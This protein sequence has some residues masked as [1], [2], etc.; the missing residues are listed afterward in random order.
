MPNNVDVIIITCFV[1]YEPRVQC[2]RHFFLQKGKNVIVITT[3]FMHREKKIRVNKADTDNFLY[4]HTKKYCKNL[5]IKR[6]LSH[7]L[8]ARDAFRQAENYTPKLIYVLVPGNALLKFGA[9][10]KQRKNCKMIVDIV[11][12]WPESLPFLSNVD[13]WPLSV[14]KKIRD[15]NLIYSDLIITECDFYQTKLLLPNNVPAHTLYWSQN[16]NPYQYVKKDIRDYINFLYLGSI[17][18]IIDIK[19]IVRLLCT[20]QKCHP[21]SIYIVGGGESK[22]EFINSLKKNNIDFHYCGFIYEH[23]RLQ[24][25]SRSCHWGINM[26]KEKTLIGLTMKSVTYMELGLPIINNVLGDTWNLITKYSSGINLRNNYTME[27]MTYNMIRNAD[28]SSMGKISRQ[29]FESHFSEMAFINK[30]SRLLCETRL[31]EL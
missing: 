25:I 1:A 2:V 4:I 24:E 11:D 27:K 16:S 15:K 7:Y 5:S 28:I 14:W 30:L 29:I 20:I 13:I 19:G 18:H 3:D 10:Y 26:M 21:V 9:A 31:G 12:L 22:E 17:N 6:L 23:K 8:Y